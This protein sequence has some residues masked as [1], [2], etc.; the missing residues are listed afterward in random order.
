M[1]NI[2]AVSTLTIVIA[3]DVIS[4]GSLDKS[5]KVKNHRRIARRIQVFRAV[6]ADFPLIRSED[7]FASVS[8]CQIHYIHQ[9]LSESS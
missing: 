9:I 6:L 7:S 1:E 3:C 5:I 8:F 2:W 4:G